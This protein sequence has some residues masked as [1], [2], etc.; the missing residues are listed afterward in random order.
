MYVT[1]RHDMTLTV[2]VALNAN[3]TNQPKFKEF[4]DKAEAVGQRLGQLVLFSLTWVYAISKAA[5]T[6][7]NIVLDETGQQVHSC[8]PL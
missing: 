4:N 7:L 2:K 3:T 1:D 8:I 5:L 6:R